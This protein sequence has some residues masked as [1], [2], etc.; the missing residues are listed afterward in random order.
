MSK[1]IEARSYKAA[2]RAFIKIEKDKPLSEQDIRDITDVRRA[3]FTCIS[4]IA[5]K[6]LESSPLVLRAMT[7]VHKDI[8]YESDSLMRDVAE[9]CVTLR[10]IMQGKRRSE[11]VKHANAMLFCAN[12]YYELKGE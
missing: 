7:A 9:K 6:G 1:K 8:T 4:N 10:R 11:P 5:K 12:M 2:E 3:L